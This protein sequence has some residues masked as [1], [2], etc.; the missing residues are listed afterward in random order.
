MDPSYERPVHLGYLDPLELVWVQAAGRMGVRILR[1][2]EL[3][4]G[5][6]GE[7]NLSLGTAD[8]LDPDD[9]V[10]QMIFHEICHWI[11]N[12]R[13]TYH[14]PDWGFPV[15]GPFD[16]REHACLRI[17]G[18]LAERHGLRDFLAPT[19]IFREYWDALADAGVGPFEPL[20]GWP[21]EE[22]VVALAQEALARSSEE[23]WGPALTEALV[24]TAGIRD[25]VQ[26]WIPSQR[27]GPGSLWGT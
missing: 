12:G 3:F 19:T 27:P 26:P 20:P 21:S 10:A 25:L 6:D 8:T 7:G 23:P 22:R 24:A 16:W 4:A 5:T 15:D 14:L 13:E 11:V 17:Q 1:D 2:P 9:C 18:I